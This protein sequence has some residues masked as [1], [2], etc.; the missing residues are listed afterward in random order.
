MC[1]LSCYISSRSAGSLLETENGIRRT[2]IFTMSVIFPSPDQKKKLT[3]HQAQRFLQYSASAAFCADRSSSQRRGGQDAVRVRMRALH[4]T[5]FQICA[6][7][8]M[9]V[10]IRLASSRLLIFVARYDIQ[11]ERTAD[12]DPKKVVRHVNVNE[13]LVTA[14]Q[15]GKRRCSVHFA[16]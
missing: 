12:V 2:D 6:C 10:F 16:I 9:H 15:H 1:G 3:S 4:R 8:C 5:S 13:K 11:P 14:G 7:C